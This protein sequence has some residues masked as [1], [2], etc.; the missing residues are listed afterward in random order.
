MTE[1]PI[2]ARRRLE[3][4]A[5]NWQERRTRSEDMR[6]Q[7]A[8][9]RRRRMT[10]SDRIPSVHQNQDWTG[11]MEMSPSG[12]FRV[13]EEPTQK[14]RLFVKDGIRWDAAWI[15][16]AAVCVILAGILLADLAGI[17]RSMKSISKLNNRIEVLG[18]KNG[19]LQN[20][21]ELS[22]GDLSVCTE[23]VKL[24]L[25]ASGG[26]TVVRLTAPENATLMLTASANTQTNPQTGNTAGD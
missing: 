18:S 12:R 19:Q 10:V 1:M 23:A 9:I 4:V 6:Q 22:T 3:D 13:I 5:V 25:I 14:Q 11:S 2:R 8:D 17:G 7:Q 21:L 24:N 15:A 20:Q 26:A 16:I